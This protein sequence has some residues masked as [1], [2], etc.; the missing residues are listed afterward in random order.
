MNGFFRLPLGLTPGCLPPLVLASALLL[1][2]ATAAR[3]EQALPAAAAADGCPVHV[4][5][6][7]DAL[8]ELAE[9]YLGSRQRAIEIY[10]LNR[11]VIGRDPNVIE[12]GQRLAIPCDAPRPAP[13]GAEPIGEPVRD[14]VAAPGDG[15]PAAA[16]GIGSG[17]GALAAELLRQEAGTPEREASPSAGFRGLAGGPLSPF[18]DRGLPMGGIAVAL[19]DAA[20]AALPG[21]GLDI[22]QV[23]D[24]AAHLEAI[25]P[26]GGFDFSFPWIYPDCTLPDLSAQERLLCD[27]FVAS[28]ILFEYVTEFYTRADGPWADAL[29]AEDLAGTRICR[30]E[31]FP[32][33]D[34]VRMGLLPGLAKLVRSPNALACLRMLDEGAVDIASMDAAI[35]RALVI[36]AGLRNPLVV[37]ET[38]TRTDGLTAVARRGDPRGAQ[39]IE[40]LNRG[41]RSIAQSGEW[42]AIIESYLRP[43]PAG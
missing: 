29:A 10:R 30:P 20:F 1:L 22:G 32:A 37:L 28:D 41:I 21:Q 4:V 35:T 24:R 8:W 16:P 11:R 23:D 42:Y 19:V 34:L 31:G 13:D 18:V 26:R 36:D 27:E 15:P 12:P 6:R 5:Q 40:A 7:G 39:A 9:A 3:A 33:D 43:A 17:A 2:P 38:L 14:I 25:L